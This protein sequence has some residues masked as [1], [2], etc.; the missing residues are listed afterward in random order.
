MRGLDLRIHADWPQIESGAWVAGSSPATTVERC[1]SSQ[2][3][4]APKCARP[5]TGKRSVYTPHPGQ[6]PLHI[7]DGAVLVKRQY[8]NFPSQNIVYFAHGSLHSRKEGQRTGSMKHC[9]PI[10]ENHGFQ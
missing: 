9:N 3:E 2:S 7:D 1:D 5:L 10:L 8:F 4:H 6:P